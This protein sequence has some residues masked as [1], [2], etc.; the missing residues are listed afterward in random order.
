MHHLYTH[1][2]SIT[3]TAKLNW[4]DSS[5]HTFKCTHCKGK[6]CA[7]VSPVAALAS[8][9]SPGF[10]EKPRDGPQTTS[11]QAV[12]SGFMPKYPV[13]AFT[14]SISDIKGQHL[15]ISC[16][17]PDPSLPWPFFMVLI[18]V[19]CMARTDQSPQACCGWKVWVIS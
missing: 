16:E 11:L 7:G 18:K 15:G 9:I 12:G 3:L 19:G 17:F 13:F 6:I 2:V 10:L 1:I 14:L 8:R 4:A 5:L